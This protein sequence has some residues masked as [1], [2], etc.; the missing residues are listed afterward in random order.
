MLQKSDFLGW[1]FPTLSEWGES[2]R[3]MWWMQVCTTDRAD[4]KQEEWT[5]LLKESKS[6]FVLSETH[7]NDCKKQS[8]YKGTEWEKLCISFCLPSFHTKSV[9]HISNIKIFLNTFF[10]SQVTKKIDIV[11]LPPVLNI[12]LGKDQIHVLLYFL[13]L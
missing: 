8:L 1:L 7:C 5:Y 10:R 9:L 2:R 3:N 11:K 6:F 4:I 12:Q 13:G